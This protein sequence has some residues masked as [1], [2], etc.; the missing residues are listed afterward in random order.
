M[1]DS[2]PARS[3]GPTTTLPRW[4]SF[5]ESR[6]GGLRGIR[7]PDPPKW[8][9]IDHVWEASFERLHQLISRKG[10]CVLRRHARNDDF[11]PVDITE[12][13]GVLVLCN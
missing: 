1:A 12:E 10:A 3:A 9:R 11:V 8:C 2:I 13:M 4:V 7:P 5:L 6:L